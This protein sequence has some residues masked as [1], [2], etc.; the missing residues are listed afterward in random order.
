MPGGARRG[1]NKIVSF[2]KSDVVSVGTIITLSELDI[3]K[4]H[5]FAGVQFFSDA[6]GAVSVIPSA[7]TVLI[8]IQTINNAPIFESVLDNPI[9]AK[10]PIT[11]TWAA[12]TQS[13]RATPT[14]I[15]G[16]T[17]Y[18]LVTTFNET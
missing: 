10:A 13:V 15:T 8:E 4:P 14:G 17:H 2:D 6:E 12:N 9:T 18:K 16:A 11:I 3:T 5:C 1:T 7:G